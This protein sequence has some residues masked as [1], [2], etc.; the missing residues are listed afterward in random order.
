MTEDLE[1]TR[2]DVDALPGPVVLEFG[3]AWCGYCQALAPQLAAQLRDF[4]GVRHVKVEDGKGKPLGRSFRVKLWPT[5]VFL[6]DGQAVR[7]V[8]RPE[9]AE[10]R[11]GLE[12]ITRPSSD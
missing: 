10:V 9:A 8:A 6:R 2:Q 3:A 7:Q 4:P 5:L 1:P 12:A 11:E